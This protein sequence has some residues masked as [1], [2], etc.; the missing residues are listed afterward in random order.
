MYFMLFWYKTFVHGTD[1]LVDSVL[2]S[3]YAVLFMLERV[4]TFNTRIRS[5][6]LPVGSH[7]IVGR[8][9]QKSGHRLE[10]SPYWITSCGLASVTFHEKKPSF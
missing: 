3:F 9:A 6:G 2:I 5:S 7:S 10:A 4:C 1:V 8:R